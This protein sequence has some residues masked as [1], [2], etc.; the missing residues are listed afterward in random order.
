M[1]SASDLRIW[2]PFT[3]RHVDSGPLRILRAEGAH[4]Y[5]DDGR[6]IIDAISSW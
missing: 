3:Q 5:T 4:L 1:G 2:H 6:R